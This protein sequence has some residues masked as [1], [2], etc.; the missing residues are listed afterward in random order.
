MTEGQLL[1]AQELE[2]VEDKPIEQVPFRMRLRQ[3]NTLQ[4]G[5]HL[6]K[7]IKERRFV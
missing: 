2:L 4:A 1:S 7:M 3:S 5:A 6:I